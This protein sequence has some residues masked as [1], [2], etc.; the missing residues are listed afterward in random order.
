ME[1]KK[2]YAKPIADIFEASED[3]LTVSG[4]IELP[5]LPIGTSR[6]SAYDVVEDM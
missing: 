6:K 3:V 2:T 5:V 4:G 1:N